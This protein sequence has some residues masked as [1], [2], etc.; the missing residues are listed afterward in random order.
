MA[1]PLF[2]PTVK[3]RDMGSVLSC[4]VSDKLGPGEISRE[5][6]SRAV[7]L[8]G[9]SGG[10]SLPNT[11]LALAVALRALGLSSGDGVVLPALAPSLW[12]RV[13]QELGLVARVAD[14]DPQSGL[15]DVV[16]AARLTQDG[17]KAI[18]VP[19]TLGMP[20]DLQALRGLGVPILEDISQ[21]LG[22]KMGDQMTGAG[23]DLC[24]LSLEP[25]CIVTCGGGALV[26][27]KG[28]QMAAALRRVTE[29]SPLYS[30]L[31]DMNA[32]LG[33]SQFAA[34][35]SFIAVR[36][37]V[38]TAYAQ[39]LLKSRHKGLAQTA[40]AEVVLSSFPVLLNDGMKEVRQYALKRNVET[41]PAF[42]DT[43][44]SLEGTDAAHC[45]NA[46]SLLLRCLLFPLYPTLGKRDV[47][48]TCKVLAT[49]P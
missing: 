16:E 11:Y 28:R 37:E 9:Q 1:V 40:E 34:L 44:A 13:V 48:T 15:I 5:L 42:A 23:G 17:A 22:G 41:A 47:E 8:L 45:V 29:S 38:A 12:L 20:V 14:V 27:A 24:L 30:Q 36:R 39:S 35:D 21:G 33:I 31:A 46:R 10:V 32:A 6:V 43:V 25:E 4:I 49:L 7:H 18:L 3:R 19:H 26:L 2:R